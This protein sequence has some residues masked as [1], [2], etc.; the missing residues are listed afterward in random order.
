M[1][2]NYGALRFGMVV[3]YIVMWVWLVGPPNPPNMDG[4]GVTTLITS[5]NITAQTQRTVVGYDENSLPS[6]QCLP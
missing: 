1:V 5:D 3:T 6:W 4:L 2:W